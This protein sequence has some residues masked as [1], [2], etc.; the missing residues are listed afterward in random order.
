MTTT[1]VTRCPNCGRDATR[2][3]LTT[4]H[5]TPVV[6]GGQRGPTMTLC[7]DCHGYLNTQYTENE[8]RDRFPTAE[9]LLADSRMRTFGAFANH[10]R[11]RVAQHDGRRRWRKGKRA[12]A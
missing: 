1:A 7:V 6:R 12:R 5:L 4:H 3:A 8:Q 11:K 10:Q 9:A 2:V